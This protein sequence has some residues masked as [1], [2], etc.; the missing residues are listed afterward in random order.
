MKIDNSNYEAFFLDFHENRLSEIQIDELFAFLE[1]NPELREEFN[2]FE[3]VVLPMDD[4][5]AFFAKDTLKKPE[6][7][8]VG[9]VDN[10]NYHELFIAYYEGDI[11]SDQTKKLMLFLRQNP[12]VNDEFEL[13]GKLKLVPDNSIVFPYKDKLLKQLKVFHYKSL[14]YISGSIA[15]AVVIAFSA[16]WGLQQ[17]GQSEL[18]V[19]SSQIRSSV[20]MQN[21]S[22]TNGS[23]TV[24]SQYS[25]FAYVN[26]NYNY[27]DDIVRKRVP[28]NQNMQYIGGSYSSEVKSNAQDY[29]VSGI[30]GRNEYTELYYAIKMKQD[31][32]YETPQQQFPGKDSRLFGNVIQNVKGN[33]SR[34][35]D[36]ISSIDGWQLAQYGVKGYNLLTDNDVDLLVKNNDNGQVSKVV[37][38]D[39]AVPVRK[40][41]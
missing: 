40:E 20:E 41:R 37:V 39:F 14:M 5:P 22:S 1:S 9:H 6:F 2:Q 30:Y 25:Q 3:H 12:H 21:N 34:V 33:A 26:H 10:T 4:V 16:F 11:T 7:I 19:V 13:Y 27:N 15:A 23:Q 36:G 28:E 18:A 24:N 8:P 31:G 38:N 32:Y 29:S 35:S 17:A